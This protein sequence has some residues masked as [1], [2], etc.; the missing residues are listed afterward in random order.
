MSND[1]IPLSLSING[2]Q[3]VRIYKNN[4][5]RTISHYPTMKGKMTS[6]VLLFSLVNVSTSILTENCVILVDVELIGPIQTSGEYHSDLYNTTT[7]LV[8]ASSVTT[9]TPTTLSATV[10]TQQ[11]V[12]RE[13]LQETVNDLSLELHNVAINLQHSL[14]GSLPGQLST[15]EPCFYTERSQQSLENL[16]PR[17]NFKKQLQDD[18]VT[19]F[20]YHSYFSEIR[21][22]SQ[23]P[24]SH[25]LEYLIMKIGE[26]KDNLRS[27]L[28]IL[29]PT[30][31]LSSGGYVNSN[32]CS[33]FG[34]SIQNQTLMLTYLQKFLPYIPS[35]IE[36]VKSQIKL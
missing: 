27:L 8:P 6:V 32:T 15:E 24:V 9:P 1:V 30:L 2:V 16:D 22:N 34:T 14:A 5:S 25:L 35:D 36:G 17:V 12:D 21:Q 23:R 11:Y 33:N 18:Y 3:V 31:S 10:T 29:D 19:I 7:S 28:R 26:L 4:N 13:T 20:N